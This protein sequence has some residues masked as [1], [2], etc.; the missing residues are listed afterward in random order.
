MPPTYEYQCRACDHLHEDNVKYA[1]RDAP[2]S[3][4]KCGMPDVFRH[5]PTPMVTRASYPDG[6]RKF[7]N[8][9][10]ASRLNREAAGTGDQQKKKEIQKEIN[11]MG[12]EI[13]KKE[14]I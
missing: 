14:G 6:V 9:R 7:T 3:C 5:F 13:S 1:D 2:R 8:F 10:E 4:P 12:V 11:K